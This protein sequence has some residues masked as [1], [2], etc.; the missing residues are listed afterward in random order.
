MAT[1]PVR[2]PSAVGRKV[3]VALQVAPAASVPQLLATEKSPVALKPVKCTDELPVLVM[4]T[5]SGVPTEE[6]RGKLPKDRLVGVKLMPGCCPTP[7][8]TT[9]CSP[10]EL[11]WMTRVP[12]RVPVVD[13]V[14]VTLT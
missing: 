8:R 1:L 9:R 10:S 14:M 11:F 7:L 5:S 2:C 13:G 6:P 12:V 4:A 3:T